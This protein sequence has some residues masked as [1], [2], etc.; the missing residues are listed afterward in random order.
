M[1]N[2]KLTIEY[3]GTDFK[4]WQLQAE[5]NRTVQG[6]LEKALHKIFKKK[7]RIYGSGR[8]DSGVHAL[9]QVAHFRTSS[10]IPVDAICRALNVNLPHDVSVLKAEEAEK[11]F[12]AQ[13]SAR[14]KMYRYTILN[15]QEPCAID[16]RFCM[17][18]IRPLNTAAMRRAAHAIIGRHDFRSFVALDQ[19]KRKKNI[20]QESS[21][22]TVYIS[23]LRKRGD[24]LIFEIEANGFLYKMV[25][26]LVGTLIAIGSAQPPFT[27]MKAILNAKDRASA[28]PTAPPQGLCLV[29]VEYT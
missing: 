10:T 25:R 6:E 22:R 29:K 20:V 5:G 15:R 19:A 7:I 27:D 18:V 28:G 9:G 3:D 21:I 8:T 1:R 11:T 12:H 24:Y 17:H 26:N 4:G 23:S 2:I 16:R 13:F 14:R